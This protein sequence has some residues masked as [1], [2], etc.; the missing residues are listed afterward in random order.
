MCLRVWV[1]IHVLFGARYAKT[2]KREPQLRSR[3]VTEV[4]LFSRPVPGGPIF[5]FSRFIIVRLSGDQSPYEWGYNPFIA[6]A[7]FCAVCG[8]EN[9]SLI[10]A[11]PRLARKDL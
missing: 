6:G 9:L 5:T 8:Y 3:C 4:R 7:E 1:R 11:A 10:S 2:F